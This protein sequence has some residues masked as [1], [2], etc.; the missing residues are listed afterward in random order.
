MSSAA[1]PQV[2]VDV[3]ATTVSPGGA[4]QFNPTTIN[5]ANGT[6]VI[7]RF[8]GIPGNHSVTQS[9][10]AEPCT[11]LLGGVDSGFIPATTNENLLSEWSFT[12]FNDQKPLWFFCRQLVPVSHCNA[13]MVFAVNPPKPGSANDFDAFLAAAKAAPTGQLTA[14]PPSPS[15]TSPPASNASAQAA[16][17][18]S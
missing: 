8:S 1:G 18:V 5:V 12:L 2:F 13:G 17:T 10:F 9:S 6:D 14:N 16:R 3:G 11:P 4:F 15:A 7:F